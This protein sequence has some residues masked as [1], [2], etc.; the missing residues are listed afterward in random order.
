MNTIEYNALVMQIVDTK[1]ETVPAAG[2]KQV[3][4]RALSLAETVRDLESML[5]E[6][7]ELID[8]FR[9]AMTLAA[10]QIQIGNVKGAWELLNAQIN[11]RGHNARIEGK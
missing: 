5:A 8:I 11:S 10:G 3:V 4:H 1:D 7:N 6:K 2:A 9:G